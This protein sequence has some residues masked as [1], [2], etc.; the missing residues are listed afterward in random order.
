MA[1]SRD[2]LVVFEGAVRIEDRRVSEALGFGRINDLHRL[3]RRKADELADFGEVFCREAKNP[4]AKGGCPT[5]HYYLNEHQATAICLWAETAKAR[6]ARKQIIEV[7]TAWRKGETLPVRQSRSS[8]PIEALQRRRAAI[9]EMAGTHSAQNT[10]L[11]L[12]GSLPIWTSGRRQKLFYDEEVRNFL[13]RAHRVMPAKDALAECE[14]RFGKD[15]TPSSS[16]LNR[17]WVKLDR[18]FGSN[19]TNAVRRLE[20]RA[21]R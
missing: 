2:D 4:S 10:D 16:A 6:Q 9:T 1:L 17:Y 19:E 5:L 21:T 3:I 7:F 15:R 20:R 11:N 14:A 12:I 13:T 8:D 18:V